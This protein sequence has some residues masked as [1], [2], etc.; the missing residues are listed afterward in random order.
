VD[1]YSNVVDPVDTAPLS[2]VVVAVTVTT[3][4]ITTESSLKIKAVVVGQP[5]RDSP[6]TIVEVEEPKS[7]S[8]RYLERNEYDVTW[9]GINEVIAVPEAST[10]TGEPTSTQLSG[11]DGTDHSN[12]TSPMATPVVTEV[13]SIGTPTAN[14]GADTVSVVVVGKT[15]G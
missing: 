1:S 11:S 10:G 2:E 4:L 14:W 12:T 13:N 5:G 7:P 9:S 3:S 6:I 15:G 8:P